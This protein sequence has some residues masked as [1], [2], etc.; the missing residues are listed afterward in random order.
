MSLRIVNL[1]AGR[2]DLETAR[3]RLLAEMEAA[4][5]AGTRL[6]KVIHGW[7]SSGAGGTLAAGIR[8]SLR[9]RVKERMAR[10]I[11]VGERFSGDTLEGRELAQHHPSV[12]SDRD[13]NRANPGVTVVEL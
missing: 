12:R 6:L 2:P 7:G 11:V 4:R 1:E 10:R 13:W 5:K 3:R 9:L 8:R